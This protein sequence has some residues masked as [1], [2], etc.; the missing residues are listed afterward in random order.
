MGSPHSVHLSK[1]GKR[2]G[3]LYRLQRDSTCHA[4]NTLYLSLIYP[5]NFCVCYLHMQMQ[6]LYRAVEISITTSYTTNVK[7]FYRGLTEI[8]IQSPF[9]DELHEKQVKRNHLS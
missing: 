6:T 8:F 5:S 9:C 2:L 4:A 7:M 3:M 1:A